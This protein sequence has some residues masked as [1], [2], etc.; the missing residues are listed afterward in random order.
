MQKCIETDFTGS[1]WQALW[2]RLVLWCNFKGSVI[3]GHYRRQ[4][5]PV[6][7]V[8]SAA[9]S[10]Q[11]PGLFLFSTFTSDII[12]CSHKNIYRVPYIL[13][14]KCINDLVVGYQLAQNSLYKHCMA[15]AQAWEELA[16][17][18]YHFHTGLLYI[19]FSICSLFLFP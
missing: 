14:I 9:R 16:G 17:L 5:V 7:W 8:C 11:P 4:G 2:A 18:E 15:T 19:Q 12:S 6:E 13:L 1:R 10:G 3:T